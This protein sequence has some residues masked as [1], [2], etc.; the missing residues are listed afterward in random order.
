M[1]PDVRKSRY[2]SPGAECPK[3]QTS[4]P[5]HPSERV[6][7]G[8]RTAESLVRNKSLGA[9]FGQLH[10]ISAAISCDREPTH[11]ALTQARYSREHPTKG[12]RQHPL[13]TPSD[14]GLVRRRSTVK[15]D[16][17]GANFGRVPR[18]AANHDRCCRVV[19]TAPEAL[20]GSRKSALRMQCWRWRSV[21]N[22]HAPGSCGMIN[23]SNMSVGEARLARLP[24]V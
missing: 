4:I 18:P 2:L 1:S 15:N 17:L 20:I 5:D 7:H 24:R 14:H 19:G 21:L 8:G 16:N 10:V 6:R 11:S 3:I 13:E 22:E 23:I 9:R 12:V